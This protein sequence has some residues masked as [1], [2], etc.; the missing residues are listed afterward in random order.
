MRPSAKPLSSAASLPLAAS[1]QRSTADCSDIGLTAQFYRPPRLT[2][3]IASRRGCPSA[4][5]CIQCATRFN[6]VATCCRYLLAESLTSEHTLK[7]TFTELSFCA[8]P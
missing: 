7:G 6:L 8:F 2:V 5:T 4:S 1:S 3:E